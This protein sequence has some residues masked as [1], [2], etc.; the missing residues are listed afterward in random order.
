MSSVEVFVVWSTDPVV[1]VGTPAGLLTASESAAARWAF[2]P[3]PVLPAGVLDDGEVLLGALLLG[4]LLLGALLL[5]LPLFGVELLGVVDPPT[6][7]VTVSE[8]L[9]GQLSCS[10]EVSWALAFARAVSSAV[11]VAWAARIVEALDGLAVLL[12]ATR[13][14]SSSETLVSSACTAN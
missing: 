14:L 3:P 11:T 5:G 7:V 13:A 12:A 8:E 9:A 4:A 10:S 6:A 1:A 2:V